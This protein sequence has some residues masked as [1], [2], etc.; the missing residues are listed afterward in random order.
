MARPSD[1]LLRSGTQ[2]GLTLDRWQEIMIKD[3]DA[4]N[5]L[6]NPPNPDEV[7]KS[8]WTQRMRDQLQEFICAA[9]L[10]REKELHYFIGHKYT[11]DEYHDFAPV[12][13]PYILNGKNLVELGKETV[14]DVSLGVSVSYTADPVTITVASTVEA[15]EIAVYYPNEDVPIHPT[16]VTSSGGVGTIKIPWA[17]L[18]KPELNDNREDHLQ[19]SETANYLET[20]D[21]KRKW[22]DASQGAAYVWRKPW[23]GTECPDDCV[24][25]CQTACVRIS[26]NRGHR[27]AEV[28]LEPATYSGQTPTVAR[29]WSYSPPPD[30]IRV[31]YVS[32]MQD[33]LTDLYT[34]RLAQVLLPF[35]PCDCNDTNFY[36]ADDRER[37][38]G[39]RTRYGNTEGAIEVWMSDQSQRIGGSGKFPS[40]RGDRNFYGVYL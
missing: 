35:E 6:N 39:Q 20:V 31:S 28:Y 37:V 18:I 11:G 38:P 30:M 4:F 9:E 1:N 5:G 19:Y 8:I 16:S 33:A 21:V 23:G 32:G 7:C 2:I 14:D 12:G 13:N 36:W 3:I 27:I 26:G 24:D 25:R 15:S 10:M 34:A 40:A 22:Y 17:R 29:C